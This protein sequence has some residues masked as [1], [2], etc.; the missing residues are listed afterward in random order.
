MRCSR[1]YILRAADSASPTLT[2][3]APY[4]MCPP[5]NMATSSSPLRPTYAKRHREVEMLS[6]SKKKCSEMKVNAR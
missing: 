1:C 3:V 5:P 2:P 4:S 6:W